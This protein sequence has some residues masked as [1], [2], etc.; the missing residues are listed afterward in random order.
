MVKQLCQ[1]KKIVISGSRLNSKQS[2]AKSQVKHLITLK[3]AAIFF[4]KTL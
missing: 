3:I 1:K 2:I 4:V